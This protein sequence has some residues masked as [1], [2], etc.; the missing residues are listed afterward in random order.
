MTPLIDEMAS[1]YKL[2]QNCDQMTA[3]DTLTDRL[4]NSQFS[5]LPT[6]VSHPIFNDIKGLN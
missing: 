1:K 3:K 6:V 5:Q 2:D 4:A